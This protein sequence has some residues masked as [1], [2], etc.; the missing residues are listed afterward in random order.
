MKKFLLPILVLTLFA[1]ASFAQVDVTATA[2]TA[3]ASYATLKGAFDAINAGTHQGTITIGISAS[4]TET[5]PAVLNASGSGAASYATIGIQPTGGAARSISG[6]ITAGS[7][8]IDFNGADNVTINGLNTGGNSLTISNTTVSATSGT[9]T[10]Q[11]RTDATNNTITNCSVLGSATMAVGTNGGN[12]FFGSGAVTTGNDN[13]TISNCNLGPA[14]ANLPSKCISFSGSSNTDPG[15]ANSGITINN[16]NIFDYFSATVSSAGIDLNSGTTNI[17]ITNNRFFQTA[18]RT[19]T[20][21]SLTHSGIRISNTSGAYTITGNTVGFAS[22]SGTGTYTLV[23]PASTGGGFIPINLSV[24]T[25]PTTSV[26]GNTIAGIAISGAG[27]GTSSSAQFRGIYVA[28]GLSN[29]GDITANTVGSQSATGSITYTSSSASASDIIAMFNFGSSNWTVQNNTIGGITASNSSTGAANVYGIRLNTLSTATTTVSSNLV[30]GTVANSLQSTS[31]ATGTQVAGIFVSTSIATV[32]SNTVRNLTAAGGTG[33]TTA[34]S[35]VGIDFISATPVNTVSQNTIFNL[36]NT[37]TTAATTLTGIHFTGATGNLVARNLIYGL[38]TAS[39]STAAEINGI[40]V[41]GG[42][43]VYRNNMIAVGAGTA[44]AIGTGSI[45]GGVNGINEPLGTD[46]FFHNSVFVGGAPTAGVGPSYAFNSSIVTNTRSFRDNIFFNARSNSGATGKNYAVRAGGTTPNPTGLTVNN[47]VYFANGT[48]AVFGFF[49][50]LD[51]ANL[52]AWKTAVGQDAGSFESNPQFNDPTNATPDLHLHPTNPTVAEGNGAD[53]GVTDDF[54]GQTRSGLTPVDIGADAGNFVGIDLAPPVI[55]YTALGDTTATGNRTLTAT[56]TDTGSGVPTTGAGL[57][58]LY[59]RINAGSY[60]AATATSLGSNQYQFTFG[61]GAVLNDTVSYYV[62]AQDSAATPNV[63][64]NPST[65]A[66][67]FTANPPAA[68]TPPTTPNSYKIKDTITGTFTVGAAGTYATLTAAVTDL[69]NKVMTGP[70]VFTLL[71]ASNTTAPQNTGEVFPIVINANSGSSATN[72]LTIKPAASVVASISGAVASGALIVV[73]ANFVTL[74]GSNSGGTDRSR[75]ITNTSATSPSVLL[76]GST[77]TTPITNG[78]L[79]NCVIINGVNTSSAVVISDSTTLGAAGFFSNITIQNNDVQKAFIGVFATGGTTPQNGSSL[80]YTQNTVNTSGANAIRNVGLYMQGVNGATVSQNTV[81]NFETASAENDVGIWLATGTINATVSG[82]TVSGLSYTGTGAQAPIGINVTGGTATSGVILAQNTVSSISTAGG[83]AVSGMTVSGATDGVTID[84]NSISGVSNSNTGTFGAFGMRLVAGNNHIVKNNFVSNVNHDM[85]GGGAFSTTFGVFGISVESGT[86]HKIYHNSVNLFGL[87]P[88]T[89]TTSLLSAA[90]SLV[91]TASTGCDVRNNIF[92]NNIT[93]GTTSVA[94]VAVYLPSGGTSAM[95]LAW[96]NNAY[97]NGTDTARQGVGQEGTTAGTTFFTT[98][99]ALKAYTSTLSAG[100]TNDNA[101]LASTSAVPFTANTNLHINTGLASTALESGGAAVGITTDFDGD[102][103]PG[104]T[105]SVNGGATAPDIGADEFD[106]V[107]VLTNDMQAT[108]FIDPTNGGSKIAG[109]S[110]SPQASFTNNGTA[111][112]TSVPVRYR[113]IGPSPSTSEVYNQTGSIA[114]IAQS[115]TTTVTF[116]STSLSA[117]SYTIKARSELVGDQVS[118]NDEISGTLIIEAPLSGAYTVGAAGNYSTLTQA[119]GKLNSLGVSGPVTITLLDSSNTTAPQNTGEVFP[120][121]INAIPG[122]SSTNTVTIKPANSGTAITGSSATALIVLNGSDFVTIDGS[123]NGTSSRDLTIT[124]SNA[125]ASSAGIWLQT[126]GADG[127]TN[128]VVKNVNLVG[129]TVTATAG[130]LFGAGSGSSTIGI[131]SAGTG[132]NNNTFQNCNITK[133]QYGIYSGGA[134]GGSK[135]TGTVITQNVMNAASPNNI[136]TGGI[137]VNFEDG[138]QITRNDISVLKNDGTIGT[139]NTA[140][141]IALGVVPN[142]TITTFTGS[143]VTGAVITRNKINGVTQLASLGYSAFGIVVNT[144]TSGT[145]LVANNMISGVLSAATAADF[146]AGIVAGGGAGSTTQVYFNSVAMTGSRNSA[147]YP[148]IALAIG[149]SNPTV[150]VRDNILVNTQTSTSTA[151]MYA[152]GTISTTFTNMTSNYN[153][154]FVSGTSGFVGQTGA[155]FGGTDQATL[156]NWQAATGTDTPNSISADPGFVAPATNLHIASVLSPVANAGQAIGGITTDFDGDPRSANP[157]IGADE[158][159]T[160]T[161]TVTGTLAA[162]STTYGTASTAQTLSVSGSAL[163]ANITATA[164]AGYEVASDA[165]TYG[166]TATF[167]QSGGSAS[168]TLSIR[169]AAL[170]APS[171][172]LGTTLAFAST[173]AATQNVTVS[174]T[175]NK[176]TPAVTATGTTSLT[177]TGS[178]QGPS[179]AN[180]TGV[181]GGIAPSGALS[182]SY[183]GTGSTTYGPSAT[184]PTNAGTYTV[185]ATVAADANYLTASSSALAFSIAKA[186]PTATLAVNNSPVTYTGSA[187]AATV[188]ITTSSV[189]GSVSNIITGG[190]ATQ[191]NAG[192]YPV[193]ANFV[194]TDTANFNTLVGQSAG[195]F[196]INQATP[197]LSVTNSPV[198]YT[199]SAQA[200]AV[201]GS[202]TGT[203]SNVKYDGSSTVPTNAGTYATTADFASGDANYGNLTGASAGNFVINQATPTLSVTNSPVTYTG[204]A[205]AAAV[206]ASATGTVSNVKYNGSSTVPTNAGTYATTADFASGDANYGNLTG[207]SAGNFIIAK[208][209]QAITG[210]P[211]TNT[212]TFGN[213]AYSLSLTGGGSGNAITYLSSNTGVATVNASGLVTIVGAGSTTIMASQ[214]GNANYNAAPDVTQTLTVNKA[215]QTI[216]GLPSTD[217]RFVGDAPYSLGLT[218]GGSGNAITYVSSNT[219]VATVSGSGTVTIVAAGSTTITA[220]QAGNANYNPATDAVQTLTVNP[221]ITLVVGTHTTATFNGS[222]TS[223]MVNFVGVPG[224]TYVM[225]YS[226]NLV[227]WTSAGSPVSTGTGS[228]TMT[229]TAAGDQTALWNKALFF[230]ASRQ[231]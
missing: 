81:G 5:A 6:A 86:G 47:N 231:P 106:G 59:W 69:N 64:S 140:F 183:V 46:S 206:S 160:P 133:T 32:S 191:T 218:G 98:F 97:F 131:T 54:D 67:G 78:T 113:I 189:P 79:K 204:S 136:T 197:T 24:N 187:Q 34:A 55:A 60:T 203:V 177:Y 200:A 18:S 213:A 8:L 125:G 99:A 23:L 44:N 207:A 134:S 143:D 151:K 146:S 155:L 199:G 210:L 228:F 188:G 43:T 225:E 170:T 84:R 53:V 26:Q 63:T 12:I 7:P 171:T 70:V 214:A 92:A 186:T 71:D 132:N 119:V 156:S 220:S 135:N 110:F 77:G 10:I 38:S 149:G 121:T 128:N 11:F 50:S 158:L 95:N 29:V 56:I 101:S 124:N 150:D 28:S 163:V 154:L 19:M 120:I 72:T 20:T 194:P 196:V 108:A 3:S 31:T 117:G 91:S 179:T 74:D 198:T 181:S 205:Q 37:N 103:R 83:T 118:A 212:K 141:G 102:T 66:S 193:T 223:I 13:N 2:G 184:Q 89:S 217:T 166:S 75:T 115:V 161:I 174:G 94:N 142:N 157:Y 48:G 216:T 209:D 114:S 27:S 57:P 219:G 107:P 30:G 192:T 138:I 39:N 211:A 14:G 165:V 127:A 96:N 40:R 61:V 168:G 4:T 93:G 1:S 147:T 16:N 90:F 152:I 112:Q 201:S 227:G 116:T 229:I 109:A 122:A 111:T 35:V 159:A 88:G 41:A 17:G 180:V 195:N 226:T 215:S 52:A 202:V 148:S 167:T 33:T 190:A 105:G 100:G 123:S 144:V 87:M 58:V 221:P 21:T 230:R 42:T 172:A 45:T 145:T 185:T 80:T 164:P 169:L 129:T 22:S 73:K 175:V 49:N 137:L 224:Q 130:T 162:F 25:T 15:T 82:N 36:S 222:I 76:F 178:P 51:V 9:S 65:G 173:G 68:S 208:A 85:T 62:V 104:P 126:N 182:F 153:D 176:A 139:S